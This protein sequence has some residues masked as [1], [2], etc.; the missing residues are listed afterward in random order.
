MAASKSDEKLDA[1][2][3]IALI[4][5]E[6]AEFVDFRFT[7]PRGKTHHTSYRATFVN[8]EIF[9]DGVMFDGSSGGRGSTN[10]I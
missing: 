9:S 4:E 5:K 7:D 6:G 8:E 10:R 2:G 1:N 3:V